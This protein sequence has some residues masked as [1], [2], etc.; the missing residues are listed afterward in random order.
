[1]EIIMYL[2]G[3]FSDKKFGGNPAGVVPDARGISPENMQKIATEIN[4]SETAFVQKIDEDNYNIR[5]FTP[6]QEVD[7]CGHATIATFYTLAA[8]GYL[9]EFEEKSKKYYQHTK[10]GKLYVEV[11]CENG[12]VQSVVMEQAKPK[13]IGTLDE[14][15][16]LLDS[17]NIN[18]DDLGLPY[19]N[20]KPQI[21]ST[22]LPDIMVPIKNKKIL[23]NLTI[24]YKKVSDL[25]KKLNVTGI[26]AFTI[27]DDQVYTR[28]FAP[29]VGI[30]EEAA[31]GTA[32]GALFYYLRE[33]DIMNEKQ[34]IIK[35]GEVLNRP[36][37]ILVKISDIKPDSIEVGG[38]ASIILEG[39]IHC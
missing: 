8:K 5:F 21:I 27:E 30:N 36:S 17:M 12:E 11:Y 15:D 16:E 38:K 33:N 6:T 7:L 24:D 1:M 20:I 18:I 10:A 14:V 4:L 37:E 39:V 28:N 3:A 22:G 26:H 31:T 34:I 23:E 9:S 32:N 2:V 25:S 13:L 35:Q 29:L 19:K